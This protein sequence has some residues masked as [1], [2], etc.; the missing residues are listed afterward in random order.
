[1][2]S[3]CS[4]FRHSTWHRG[5]SAVLETVEARLY[6]LAG[7]AEP[8]MTEDRRYLTVQRCL[9]CDELIRVIIR[10]RAPWPTGEPCAADQNRPCRGMI[11]LPARMTWDEE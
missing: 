8:W 7:P 6:H 5:A 4:R 3:L 2:N 10:D 9:R 11:G 1:M